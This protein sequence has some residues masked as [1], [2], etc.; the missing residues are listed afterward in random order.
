M[1]VLVIPDEGLSER[2]NKTPKFL[3][4]NAYQNNY[5]NT[6]KS[7]YDRVLNVLKKLD[8]PYNLTM[9]KIHE[10]VI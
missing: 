2:L 7:L 4:E 5:D 6:N 8:T 9:T 10:P 3:S 1:S